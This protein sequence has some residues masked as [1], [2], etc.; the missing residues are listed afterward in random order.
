MFVSGLK[1]QADRNDNTENARFW[2]KISKDSQNGEINT[3]RP[4]AITAM[5]ILAGS[6]VFS[7]YYIPGLLNLK[8]PGKSIIRYTGILSM[9][10]LFFL[11][12]GP[13]AHDTVFNIAGALG[14]VAM[15]TTLVGLFKTRLYKLLWLSITCVSLLLINNYIYYTKD[16]LFYLPLIQKISFLLFILW[17]SLLD[18]LLYQKTKRGIQ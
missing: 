9:I 17:F 8:K 10:S 1:S 7:W 11:F 14:V 2:S 5:I 3:A 13:D 18:I 6:L 15:T 12:A 4:I 16:Y